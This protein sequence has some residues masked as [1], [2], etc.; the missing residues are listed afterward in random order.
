MPRGRKPSRKVQ[1][2]AKNDM[3]DLKIERDHFLIQFCFLIKNTTSDLLKNAWKM[4]YEK[5]L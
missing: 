5:N 1:K 2:L 3:V 4:H